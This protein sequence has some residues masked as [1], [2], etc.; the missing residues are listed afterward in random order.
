LTIAGEVPGVSATKLKELIFTAA[1][2]EG[3]HRASIGSLQ[4]LDDAAQ[5]YE[6]WLA[7]GF[8]AGMEYMKRNPRLRTS[9]ALLYPGS[10]SAIIVAVSYY[11]EFPAGVSFPHAGRVARY[12]V[13]LDYHAVI[14]ARL[15]RLKE[16]IES[17]IGRPLL[18]KAYADDVALHEQ[19]FASRHGVGFKGR[20]T[21]VIGPKLSGSYY[22][23][24]E[25]F[26]DLEL[27]AD[28][29]YE[30]TCGSCFRCGVACPTEAITPDGH[31]DANLC[32]SY[33]T[34]E[35]KGGIPVHLRQSMGS[36]LFGCDVCQEV[37]P[38]NQRPPETMWE[39]FKPEKGVGHEVSLGT[40]L[41]LADDNEFSARFGHTPLR[42]PK[43]RG[44]L[45][46]A[47][48]VTGNHLREISTKGSTREDASRWAEDVTEK[49]QRLAK[50]EPDPML[51]EHAFWALTFS[52][53]IATGRLDQMVRD[54]RDMDAARM[55][56][57]N[58]DRC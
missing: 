8:A 47:L 57:E 42:R 34:I 40:I 5:S 52:H 24:A 53:V 46:N 12:A 17:Q 10:R 22:F 3:F 26:T 32:I 4:P 2:E 41:D 1:R 13:G 29:K 25:L 55:M 48:V 51:R 6:E 9:P 50:S 14:R 43:R 7:R 19:S 45:R 39:E 23:L 28:E 15:R 38:Y 33:L 16:R 30:G 20:N 37:C 18:A 44:L 21:M 56:Q 49:L 31:I 58:L 36:W 35:N 11:N 27:E 54:E